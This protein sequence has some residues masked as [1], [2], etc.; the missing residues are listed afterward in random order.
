MNVI[1]IIMSVFQ[2][3]IAGKSYAM[4]AALKNAIRQHAS[5]TMESALFHFHVIPVNI[6]SYRKLDR[7]IQPKL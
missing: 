7:L 4:G 1:M 3:V 2:A 5:G 6:L